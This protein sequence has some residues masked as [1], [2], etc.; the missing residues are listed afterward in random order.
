[1]LTNDR[2]SE[3]L[4]YDPIGGEFRWRVSRRKGR[5][6]G[7]IAGSTDSHGYRQVC[8]DGRKYLAHRIAWL[9]VYGEWPTHEI[10]HI[11]GDKTDNRIA[12]LRRATRHLNTQNI[13]AAR[14]DS[15]NGLAGVMQRG[16]RFGARIT[17]NGAVHFLG[18]YDT[19]EQAHAA[20][21]SAKRRLHMGCTI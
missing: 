12:N 9:V 14:R 1:M 5:P 13:R 19:P 21:L 11:N 16:R 8:I 20:Y 18:M 7:D 2:V 17:A 15:Q 3:F 6:S 4:T 10:D